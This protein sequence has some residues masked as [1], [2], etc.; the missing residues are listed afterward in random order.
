MGT[1]GQM[2]VKST[3]SMKTPVDGS[4]NPAMGLLAGLGTFVLVTLVW[5][6]VGT[7]A[8]WALDLNSSTALWKLL[9]GFSFGFAPMLVGVGLAWRIGARISSKRT[10]VAAAAVSL[11]LFLCYL[12]ASILKVMDVI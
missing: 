3:C 10:G 5:S 7:L 6:V 2:E 1:T 9:L 8:F 4:R 12:V 11:G